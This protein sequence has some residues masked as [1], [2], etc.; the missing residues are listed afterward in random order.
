VLERVD[1]GAGVVAGFTTR[2]GGVSA[3]DFDSLN[4]AEHVGDELTAVQAN[5][6]RLSNLLGLP[7]RLMRQVHGRDVHVI[8]DAEDEAAQDADALVTAKRGLGLSVLVA[9][10]VPVLL[11]DP[12]V[13]VVA[14]VHAGR[15][16]VVADVV[17]AAVVAMQDLGAEPSRMRAALGPAICPA[18]YPLGADVQAEVL[19]VAP[20]AA[21]V[22]A[23]GSPAVDLRLA[24]AVRL[25][26]LGIEAS[27]SSICTAESP[28]HFSYRRDRRTG[29]TAG[30]IGLS[31]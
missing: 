8:S 7:L 22:A 4:L 17:G 12:D 28:R 16:G 19:Q 14:A 23:D 27:V 1:L 10:C 3:G 24:V 26:R 25:A 29:R 30:V 2:I 9:D 15:R 11:S 5:R 20:E 18:C 6:A 21:A 13:G 31:Q